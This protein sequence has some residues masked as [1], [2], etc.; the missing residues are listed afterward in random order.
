MGLVSWFSTLFRSRDRANDEEEVAVPFSVGDIMVRASD[1]NQAQKVTRTAT[2]LVNMWKEEKS[3]DI[4]R[5]M[6]MVDETYP[7]LANMADIEP[8]STQWVA[9][10]GK[11]MKQVT[12]SRVADLN[13]QQDD[14][15]EILNKFSDERDNR[16]K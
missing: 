15:L 10:L 4:L 13:K 8:V 11:A 16:P 6:L 7:Y 9:E 5:V 3:R 12:A 2:Q 1:I 14:L